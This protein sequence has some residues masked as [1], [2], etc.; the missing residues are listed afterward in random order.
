MTKMDGKAHAL[1]QYY[2]AVDGSNIKLLALLDLLRAFESSAPFG[3][4][5]CCG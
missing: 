5:V 4:A 3:M 1:R 2:I